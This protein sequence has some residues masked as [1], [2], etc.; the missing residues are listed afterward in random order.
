MTT[1]TATTTAIV[2]AEPAPVAFAR[3]A[4]LAHFL[5]GQDAKTRAE[6]GRALARFVDFAL[7]AYDLCLP[8]A[9][10]LEDWFL[11]LPDGGAANEV[12]LRWRAEL[13]REYAPKTVN[14]RLSALRS[15]VRLAKLVG[16]VNWTL[17]V[18]N[19]PARDYRHAAGIGV[20][21]YK[22]LLE[23]NERKHGDTPLGRR[24]K[25]M[26]RL[27]FDLGLRKDSVLSLRLCDVTVDE[28]DK[29]QVRPL[30]K[31]RGRHDS[32]RD[33]RTLPEGTRKAVAAWLEVH[34]LA[35]LGGSDPLF[36]G[37]DRA[38]KF[39][40]LSAKGAWE[41][42]KELGEAAGIKAWPHLI[43][44]TSCTHAL[45]MTNGDV[46]KVQRF[47]GHASPATTMIY[48]EARKDHA[49]EVANLIA[50]RDE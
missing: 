18:K 40:R 27:M 9:R 34:P 3:Q 23:A 33:V 25:A 45:D 16:R 6:Y 36:V 28:A 32:T 24:N 43:R 30:V 39:G 35:P 41:V 20:G 10:V 21:G 11:R 37:L 47:M 44:H 19:V 14:Q 49:G 7:A 1:D 5:E 13:Q 48:D 26:L 29:G 4:L 15:L 42:V 50:G 46:R 22:K 2:A 12:A 38:S 31:R 17:D 8:A